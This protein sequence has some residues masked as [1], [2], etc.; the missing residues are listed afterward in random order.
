MID[1]SKRL[2]VLLRHVENVRANCF[3]LAEALIEQDPN[4][5]G[6][7]KTLIANGRIHDA[8]K[9]NG[10]EWEY[11][12]ADVKE[13]HPELFK[14]AA[15]QHILTNM[16]HPEYWQGIHNM[17]QIYL[18]ELA[19]DWCSRSQEFGNDPIE[20]ARD[21]GSDKYKFPVSG[22]I[23]KDILRYTKLILEPQFK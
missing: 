4:N 14:M 23:Y 22:R 15:Q 6:F 12:H 13:E 20:W 17:P 9:F 7:A 16:H 5:M 18:A 11:L 10:I 21:I 3:K 8:S 2:K 1:Y 19:A